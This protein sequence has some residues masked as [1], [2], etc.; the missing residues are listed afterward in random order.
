MTSSL[1]Y[2][3]FKLTSFPTGSLYY[4]SLPSVLTCSTGPH[5][6]NR[7][8]FFWEVFFWKTET[9]STPHPDAV[10]LCLPVQFVFK[11][12]AEKTWWPFDQHIYQSP[13]L[14]AATAILPSRSIISI[15]SFTLFLFLFFWL[16]LWTKHGARWHCK[17]CLLP[18]QVLSVC[19][20]VPLR[21]P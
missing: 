16:A 15:L 3:L 14:T 11:W 17:A 6:E 10:W 1:V 19:S 8:F 9:K 4:F 20:S 2:P 13:P 5:M 18:S 12:I 21:A 7:L